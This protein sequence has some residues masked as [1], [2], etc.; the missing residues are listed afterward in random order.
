MQPAPRRILVVA[1]RTAATPRLL[2]EVA[3][4][5]TR[6]RCEFTLMVP[7]VAHVRDAD[8]KLETALPLR[9][10]TRGVGGQPG[11]RPGPA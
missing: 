4:R 6:A 8:W 5:A 9:G 3:E 11:R 7:D 1:N 2:A 10:E